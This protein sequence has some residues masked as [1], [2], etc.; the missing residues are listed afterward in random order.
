MTPQGE[1]ETVIHEVCHLSV[2]SQFRQSVLEGRVTAHGIEWFN[3]MKKCGI[4]D[5]QAHASARDFTKEYE[6]DRAAGVFK[7]PARQ[8]RDITR[9]IRNSSSSLWSPN[10]PVIEIES[11]NNVQCCGVDH[12]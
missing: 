3:E 4:S 1:R 8:H 11:E 5:I 7:K 6:I 2:Y 10:A 12:E 9:R